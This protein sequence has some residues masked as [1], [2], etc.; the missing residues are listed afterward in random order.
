M[1]ETDAPAGDRGLHDLDQSAAIRGIAIIGLA[2]CCVPGNYT[3]VDHALTRLERGLA[4]ILSAEGPPNRDI[5]NGQM[6][7]GMGH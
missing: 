4:G 6:M 2:V 1:P 3:I 5:Y 7:S